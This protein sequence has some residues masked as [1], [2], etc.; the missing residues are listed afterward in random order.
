MVS[1]TAVPLA[2]VKT[3]VLPAVPAVV[4]TQILPVWSIVKSPTAKVPDAGAPDAV[5]PA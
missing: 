3:A 2:D 1:E 5:A 4:H